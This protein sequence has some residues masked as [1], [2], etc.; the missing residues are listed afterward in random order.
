MGPDAVIVQKGLARA[1]LPARAAFIDGQC[2]AMG[3]ASERVIAGLRCHA[4][5]GRH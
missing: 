3:D 2:P 5:D 4:G 1:H